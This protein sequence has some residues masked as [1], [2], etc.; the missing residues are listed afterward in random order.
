MLNRLKYKGYT[1]VKKVFL[2]CL[3]MTSL[4]VRADWLDDIVLSYDDK[5]CFDKATAL[6]IIVEYRVKDEAK[7]AELGK[8]AVQTDSPGFWGTMRGSSY[9]AELALLTNQI[10]YYK[11]I[12]TT[13]REFPQN[14]KEEEAFAYSLKKLSRYRKRLEDLR[15]KYRKSSGILDKIKIGTVIAAKETQ[16]T[17]YK[18]YVK[19]VLL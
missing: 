19:N 18:A 9:K 4:V 3:V 17:T 2:M 5:A 6:T 16:L 15:N 8:N 14:K 11:K 10:D 7:R 12:E 13:I 1:M